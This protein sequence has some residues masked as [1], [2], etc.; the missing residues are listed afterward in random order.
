MPKTICLDFNGVLD[1]YQG[2]AG[3][4]EYPPREGVR[5]FLQA[6]KDCG[7]K[8]VVLT[9]VPFPAAEWLRKHELMDLVSEVTPVKPPAICYVDDRAICFR[10][11]FNETLREIET[12][13]AHWERE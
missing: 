5:E 1:D 8:I 9:A 10:G 4:K 6:L 12:F 13:K 2:Y 11:D 7:Y 3:G